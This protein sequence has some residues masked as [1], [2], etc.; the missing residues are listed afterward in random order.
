MT[1]IEHANKKYKWFVVDRQGI[2]IESG[3]EDFGDANERARAFEAEG[4]SPKVMTK[5]AVGAVKLD[6]KDPASWRPK[7]QNPALPPSK[8]LHAARGLFMKQW[9][10]THGSDADHIGRR[11]FEEQQQRLERERTRH[12]RPTYAESDHEVID[13]KLAHR[14]KTI[15]RGPGVVQNPRRSLDDST[16]GCR[17]CYDV[18]SSMPDY[19][20]RCVAHGCDTERRACGL[21][22]Q[23]QNPRLNPE[24]DMPEGVGYYTPDEV[25]ECFDDLSRETRTRLWELLNELVKKGK[26]VPVGGD[27][28]DGTIEYPPEPDA[29]R[30]GK[31]GAVWH[32]L[33]AKQQRE[34]VDAWNARE[35][36]FASYLKKN[37]EPD[38]AKAEAIYEMWHQKE[39]HRVQVVR[40]GCDESDE[41]VCV[42]KAF[43][44]TYRS[45]KWKKGNATDD[46]VHTF[47]SKPKVYMLAKHVDGGLKENPAK[48][49]GKLLNPARNADGQFAVAEL[50]KP[51]SFTLDNGTDEG[52]EVKIHSGAKVYGCTDKKTVL[53]VDPKWGLIVVRGGQM[54]FDERGI[55]K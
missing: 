9:R 23:R 46:Y 33:N 21:R 34:I 20:H 12:S 26:A 7:R 2:F 52:D 51:L 47:D 49:A 44:I 30:S 42:G 18:I 4:G 40:P 41:M 31:M 16:R 1:D 27:G 17:C 25:A 53:I 3:W 15:V 24:H 14:A 29:Y 22:H 5:P 43:D 55:V 54:H 6:P 13:E 28:S 10:R 38:S 36:R 11:R 32:K 48:T 19:C 39:P 45:G 50:A 37:P 35:A 8:A